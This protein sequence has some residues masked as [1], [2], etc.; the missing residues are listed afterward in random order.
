MLA[1]SLLIIFSPCLYNNG[2]LR[3]KWKTATKI[4]LHSSV[5]EVEKEGV[6]L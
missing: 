5:S 1:S 4:H 6:A 3:Q 2:I